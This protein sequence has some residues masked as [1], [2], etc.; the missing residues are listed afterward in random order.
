MRVPTRNKARLEI[1]NY[2][3]NFSTAKYYGEKKEGYE[4]VVAN[5]DTAFR[6]HDE[7]P[8]NGTLCLL[9]SAG[10]SKFYLSWLR[11]Y[12]EEGYGGSW[13]L[14]SI[15]DGS[16]CWWTNVKLY[17][18]PKQNSDQHPHW[19]WN[20]DQWALWE[21][22]KRAGKRRDAYI[23]L[24]AMPIFTEDGGVVLST[25]TRF[26]ISNERSE[27]KFVN[28]KKVKFKEMLEFY[29]EAVANSKSKIA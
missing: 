22:W 23:T 16:L 21:R 19:Q 29:D 26:S 25:R 15:E 18:Y 27:K 12:K 9:S 11:G 7:I 8:P 5:V 6:G 4:N 17:F 10:F 20:D 28:W 2:I 24:P 13:L 1:L 3:L 14:E